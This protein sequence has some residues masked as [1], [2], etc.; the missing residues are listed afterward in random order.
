MIVIVDYGLGNVRAFESL[1]RKINLPCS[2]AG[3]EDE[4]GQATKIILPGVGSFD[5]AMDSLIRSGMREKLDHMVVDL[6]VDLLASLHVLR[7]KPTAN[8]VTLQIGV[9]SFGEF[10]VFRG[11]ADEQRIEL[12]GRI[13]EKNWD[14]VDEHVRQAS[15]AKKLERQVARL[16]EGTVVDGRGT[17]VPARVQACCLAEV[18][19]GENCLVE[20]GAAEVGVAEVELI[21][22]CGDER[23][24]R[25]YQL[26]CDEA[27][28]RETIRTA[29]R[30]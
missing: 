24:A 9:N 22:H 20:S 16:L 18:E 26:R 17:E 4:L 3:N 19:V 7:R 5:F 14:V 13:V 11:I 28:S 12:A 8:P 10:L 30:S 15:A 2:I 1:Y 25:S 6:L 29:V 23:G 27:Q 21:N